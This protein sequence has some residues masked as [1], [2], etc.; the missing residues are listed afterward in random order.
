MR[1]RR[2]KRRGAVA[3]ILTIA[4]GL[5]VSTPTFAVDRL[6]PDLRADVNRDGRVSLSGNGDDIGEET[7]TKE[8]GA[9]FLPN[10]DD[11]QRRCRVSQ[12]DMDALGTEVDRTLA[13][14]HDAADS[15]V[16]G[17][18]DLADLAR[19][20]IGA[21]PGLSKTASGRLALNPGEENYVRIFIRR[22]GNFV[23]LL[24]ETDGELSVAQLRSGV[25]LAVEGRD[26][27]RDPARWD[28]T[29]TVT[30]TVEDRGRQG[31]DRVQLKVAP[32]LLQNDLQKATTVFAAQP[33]TGPGFPV[34]GESVSTGRADVPGEWELFAYSLVNAA[35]EAQL[36]RSA[37]RFIKGTQ[38][39]W[40]DMWWQDIFEP[41]TVSMPA[42][43]GAQ[44][45]RIAIRSANLWELAKPDGTVV[46]TLR[47]AGRMVFRDLRGPGVGVVQEFTDQSRPFRDDLLNMG[48]NIESLPAYGTYPHGR[49]V[50]GSHPGRKPDQAFVRMFES[51]GYQPPIV[52]DTSWLM[53]GHADETMHVVPAKNSLGWT[54]MVADPRLAARTLKQAQEQGAGNVKLFADTRSP[55]KPSVNEVLKDSELMTHN[56]AAAKHIDEQ[57]SV[58]LAETGL[59]S[60]DLIP[61]PVLFEKARESKDMHGYRAVTPGIPNGLSLTAKHFA[62]PDPHGPVVNGRDLFKAATE[63]ALAKTGV[64]VHWVEDFFWAHLGGGEVHCATNAWR[65]TSSTDRWWAGAQLMGNRPRR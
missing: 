32:M 61:V 36:P 11:D 33:N 30:L 15:V 3:G 62:A 38:Q 16:N 52:I 54:L 28:G 12:E 23:P 57:I 8:R 45:M 50:Y 34:E 48:G 43:N 65:D 59:R 47:P 26:V 56:E 10:L 7:Q 22:D 1:S 6:V 17:P 21:Q 44:A 25:E 20:K 51:Q 29:V 19:M 18:E 14:C 40:K 31:T 5:L 4:A 55:E 64:N 63:T 49:V 58:M 37:T 39:W 41:A 42:P 46:R 9:I 27:I 2:A 53:V 60:T 35:E 13:A 24:P